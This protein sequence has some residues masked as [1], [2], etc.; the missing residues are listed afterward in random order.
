MCIR[1]FDIDYFRFSDKDFNKRSDVEVTVR[2]FTRL[3]W[4]QIL[5]SLTG[6]QTETNKDLW[7]RF[8][9]HLIKFFRF[10]PFYSRV[11]SFYSYINPFY[12]SFTFTPWI[13]SSPFHSRLVDVSCGYTEV[14]QVCVSDLFESLIFIKHSSLTSCLDFCRTLRS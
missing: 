1:R 5:Y 10:P 4:R 14:P 9:S 8:L 2:T 7:R 6:A 13:E 3:S 11:S 12:F